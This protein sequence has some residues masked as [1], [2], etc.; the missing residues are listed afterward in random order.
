LTYGIADSVAKKLD[1]LII[2]DENWDNYYFYSENDYTIKGY[3]ELTDQASIIE[4]VERG[5]IPV[6]HGAQINDYE[7]WDS[8]PIVVDGEIW[9]THARVGDRAGGT[10]DGVMQFTQLT[11]QNASKTPVR[12]IQYQNSN[13][14]YW[15]NYIPVVDDGNGGYKL[16]C[17]NV[18]NV[19]CEV[20]NPATQESSQETRENW[21]VSIAY[22]NDAIE[23]GNV[24]KGGTEGTD[25]ADG[26]PR[27]AYQTLEDGN[28]HGLTTLNITGV[29]NIMSYGEAP[30]DINATMF[31]N[32]IEIEQ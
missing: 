1:L 16:V 8:L 19:E 7:S 18:P 21:P 22:E 27:D 11:W 3:N 23:N 10:Y 15:E 14:P 6:N 26:Q 31:E 2:T 24:V 9:L 4:A 32:L 29:Y 5:A 12:L 20:F 17:I 13:S 25:Y 28:E 30:D